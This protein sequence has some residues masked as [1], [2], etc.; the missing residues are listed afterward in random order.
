[1]GI[2]RLI[3]QIRTVDGQKF[4]YETG[5]PSLTT[6]GPTITWNQQSYQKLGRVVDLQCDGTVAVN[7][8]GGELRI[9]SLPF[10]PNF[11]SDWTDFK[12]WATGNGSLN[13]PLY[14]QVVDNGASEDYIRFLDHAL[15]SR[16]FQSLSGLRMTFRIRYFTTE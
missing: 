6:Y 8:N 13:Y 1:M 2:E 5:N 7:T 12:G 16:S 4:Q 3:P 9:F 11:D 14:A 10:I 15:T